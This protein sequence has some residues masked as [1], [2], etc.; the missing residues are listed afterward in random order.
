M[1]VSRA[2]LCSKHHEVVA[3]NLLILNFVLLI[4][5]INNQEDH[6]KILLMSQKFMDGLRLEMTR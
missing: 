6:L 4:E 5:S 1:I 2:S 3:T